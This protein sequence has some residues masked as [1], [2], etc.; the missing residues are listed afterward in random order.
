MEKNNNKQQQKPIE[1]T[2]QADAKGL[3]KQPN[4]RTRF[5]L[6]WLAIIILLGLLAGSFTHND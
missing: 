1:A 4:A 2:T 3:E 5:L 6:V